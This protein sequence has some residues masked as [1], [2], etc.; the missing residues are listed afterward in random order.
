MNNFTVKKFSSTKAKTNHILYKNSSKI[1]YKWDGW[2][3]F[4][5]SDPSN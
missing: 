3:N 1:W 4:K 2:D 5:G